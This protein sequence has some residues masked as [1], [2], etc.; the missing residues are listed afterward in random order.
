[1][2]TLAFEALSIG[3]PQA[4]GGMRW[5][6]RC[7]DL[8][9]SR[10]AAVAL[11][12]ESG[13][14]KSL[15][16]LAGIGLLPPTAHAR[17]GVRFGST[18]LLGLADARLAELRGRQVAMIFQNPTTSLNPY[19]TIGRQIEIVVA[20]HFS[21]DRAARRQRVAQALADVQLP[22]DAAARHP[23]QLSGGQLQR[24]MIAMALACQPD[25][26]IADEPTTA[27]D[28]T[29][30]ARVMR[31]LL[32]L[33]QRGMGLLLITHDLA[34]VAQSCE[35]VHVMYAGCIVES[36]PVRE[37]FAQPA[38]PYT[39]GLLGTQPRLGRPP[40]RLPTLPGG[41]PGADALARGC[42]FRDRC[43]SATARCGSEAPPLQPGTGALRRIACHHPL[44]QPMPQPM[45]KPQA[46]HG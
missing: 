27:L 32:A 36:G 22:A 40:R 6:V 15:S 11:V 19:Y 9:V 20:A 41:L 38:H 16:A 1:M 8:S 37:V 28:V 3:F 12:G 29:V 23:H 33:V 2:S 5:P 21:L 30:Q 14:G 24:A 10:G 44:S 17:G 7:C 35:Q 42:A 39:V 34:L 4:G 25:I 46:S 31:L 26:L 13:S 18:P 45:V 43:T